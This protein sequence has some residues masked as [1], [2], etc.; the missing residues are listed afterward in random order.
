MTSCSLKDKPLWA[1][2]FKDAVPQLGCDNGHPSTLL[3]FLQFTLINSKEQ[4]NSEVN[5]SRTKLC[6]KT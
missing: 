5:L 2:C 1:L 3:I 6:Y 4:I